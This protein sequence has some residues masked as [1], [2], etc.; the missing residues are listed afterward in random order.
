VVFAKTMELLWRFGVREKKKWK[1]KWKSEKWKFMIQGNYI[2][3]AR[4]CEQAL[5]VV[6]RKV[7]NSILK[8]YV[9][10]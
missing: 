3:K 8:Y 9:A 2:K 1:E 4:S 6:Y 10:K 7:A 5:S